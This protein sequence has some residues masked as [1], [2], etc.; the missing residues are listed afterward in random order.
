VLV[1]RFWLGLTII[2]GTTVASQFRYTKCAPNWIPLGA[3]FMYLNFDA[4]LA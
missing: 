4:I 3:H 2:L 1:W